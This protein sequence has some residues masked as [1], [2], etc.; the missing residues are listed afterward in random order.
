MKAF[1]LYSIN[2][3]Y[4]RKRTGPQLRLFKNLLESEKLSKMKGTSSRVF[5]FWKDFVTMRLSAK[6]FT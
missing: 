4:C 3:L 5:K 6:Y 1:T 2:I